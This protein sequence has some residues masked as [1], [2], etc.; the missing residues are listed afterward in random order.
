MEF[1]SKS[2]GGR[3]FTRSHL[4][5]TLT[6]L[7]K[8][9][10]GFFA[11]LF[12]IGLFYI[13]AHAIE[14]VSLALTSLLLEHPIRRLKTERDILDVA[15]LLGT[16]NPSRCLRRKKRKKNPRQYFL[17]LKAYDYLQR[18]RGTSTTKRKVLIKKKPTRLKRD[19]FKIPHHWK[20]S[21]E[22]ERREDYE[23]IKVKF[24]HQSSLMVE[25]HFGIDFNDF[26]SSIDPLYQFEM[27]KK[28]SHPNFLSTNSPPSG[29]S[30][31]L[32]R[33]RSAA[34]LLDTSFVAASTVDCYVPTDVCL[35]RQQ[36][37]YLSTHSLVPMVIDTGASISLTPSRSDFISEIAPCS[38]KHIT[39]L[40]GKTVVT[41]K[42]TVEWEVRDVLG[43]R[44]RIRTVAYLVPDASI[45]LFSPQCYFQENHA[46]SLLVQHSKTILTLADK[47]TLEFPYQK[48]NI[49]MMLG[50][51]AQVAGLGFNEITYLATN[52]ESALLS[53]NA[54]NNQNLT[55]A[56]KELLLNH[57]KYG[58]AHFQWIQSLLATPQNQEDSPVLPC[59][60]KGASTTARTILCA[61]CQLGKQTRRTPNQDHFIRDFDMAIRANDLQ[62]G[63]KVSIDSYVSY[64]PGRLPQTY[65][66]EPPTNQY[67]GGTIF[68][69]H[70]TAAIFVKNQVSLRAGE[71]LQAKIEFERWARENNVPNIRSFR[72]D[73]M[74]FDSEVWKI[75]LRSKNQTIDF[76]GVGAHHQNAVA[77]RAIQTVVKWARTMLLHHL[78]HWPTEA[79]TDLWPFALEHAVYIWNHLPRRDTKIA[80]LELF[81][82][83]RFPNYDMLSHM[84]VWGCPTY[85]LDPKLQDGKK[86]PKWKRRARRGLYLGYSPTHSSTV[87]R[88]LNLATGNVSPQYH[89]VCDD[90]FTTVTN[91]VDPN[92]PDVPFTQDEW[93]HLIQTGYEEDLS[94][95]DRDANDNPIPPALADEWLT[96]PER[97]L[98]HHRRRLIAQQRRNRRLRQL[99]VPNP[100]APPAGGNGGNLPQLP[101]L[102]P[103]QPPGQIPLIEPLNLRPDITDDSTGVPEQSE[104]DDSDSLSVPEGANED[105]LSELPTSD[106]DSDDS[107][108]SVHS[109][110][111]TLRTLNPQ[112][113]SRGG[114]RRFQP[115]KFANLA[116]RKSKR[117]LR[118]PEAHHSFEK[119]F[120]Y[121][122]VNDQFLAS[123]NWAETVE[124]LRS[125]E[126]SKLWSLTTDYDFEHSTCEWLH[127]AILAAKAN[128]EDNPSWEEAMNGPLS[129]GYWESANKEV[130]TLEDMD[131]WDVIP[132]TSDMNV[133]PS[134]W[135]FKCKRFPD[136]SVRKLKGRFC[137]RGDR[138][139][140]GID[141][142]SSEIYSPVVSWNT[143]RLLLILSVVLGLQTKQVD[144]T[145][146]F[147]HAPIGDLDVFCEMPRGFSEPGC[148]LKLKKSLYGLRQAPINF[149]NH[150]KGKLEH[151]GFKSND[152]IDSCLFISDKVICLVYVDDTLFFSPKQEYI[153]E[154]IQSLVDQ[155]V[156]VEVEDSVAGFLGVHMERDE[157]NSSIKLTQ[158]GLT[159]RIIK[160]LDIDDKPPKHTPAASDPLGKDPDGDP[161]DGRYSYPSVVGMLLYLC[162]H[163]RPDIQF[164]VSQCA[165]FIHGTKRSH[166]IALERIGQYLKSTINEGL[167]LKPDNTFNIDCHVDADFAGLYAIEDIMDPSCVKSRTGFV[168]SISKCPVVWCS[169]L[170]TDIATATME[171]EYN[172]LSTAMRD[173]LPLRTVFQEVSRGLGISDDITST[174]KTTVWEDNMGCLTLSKLKPGQYTPRSKHYAVKYHWFRSHL[175]NST[176]RTSVEYVQSQ[177]QL[178]DI[179]TK[180]LTTEKFRT[181]RKLL[182]G[183]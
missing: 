115:K 143:V 159:N 49:P 148:V 123:L 162:G 102:I 22:E 114:R 81:A 128:S 52:A 60:H 78:L 17:Y 113:P 12:V 61:A 105:D 152:T 5:A 21:S 55:V 62:P 140:D 93:L 82:R 54:E 74:P 153:D 158:K 129:D 97:L 168:L 6:Q 27:L 14:K 38:L 170:Q 29:V 90:N 125:T 166:E 139:K 124:T 167:I 40:T 56:E 20:I 3:D 71:T 88:I 32:K 133:L 1:R 180:G 142:D 46:G 137:V 121:S 157:S 119:K 26:I 57:F 107:A 111:R 79:Q 87:S 108:R 163:S 9:N 126:F 118:R 136:G 25:A 156:Q 117:K 171:A 33:A 150:I 91:L 76:S 174:F 50:P 23:R 181:I 7:Q 34:T 103:L 67:S 179:L 109:L 72:S 44:K 138:Q 8:A 104:A 89:Y 178:A 15:Q 63:D 173:L 13:E 172:A 100:P 84:H 73:N 110:N 155:G 85:V 59:R 16:S 95:F 96:E 41:G 47:T 146:A 70:A 98:R 58:H 4:F 11:L 19:V 183:W 64:A 176:N 169:K 175:S 177:F 66:K 80:P 36:S 132:R 127:P 28:L 151:A 35:S 45:R 116:Y 122:Q 131:V 94:A 39:G 160:A 164:A 69:D 106:T 141:Y 83:A 30:S 101:L 77:E 37:V 154:A 145:A 165:R 42:G 48:N 149:F 53:V 182:C 135:A 112:E 86:L 31:N 65:G 51:Q 161:P 147:V 68:Y 2:P 92:E 144:Y 24:L 120:K 130:K 43:V 10:P 75:D 18:L 99:P 134:T